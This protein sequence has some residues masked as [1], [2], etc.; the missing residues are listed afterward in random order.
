VSLG[1][2]DI[3]ALFRQA[4]DEAGVSGTLTETMLQRFHDRRLT[5]EA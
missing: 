1:E 2:F 4:F 3:E 5:G